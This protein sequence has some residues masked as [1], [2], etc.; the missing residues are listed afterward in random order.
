MAWLLLIVLSL[1]WGSS[2]IL[3]K[4]ALDV[5][6]PGEVGAIR[7][8]SAAIFI[9][10]VALRGLKTVQRKHWK[11]LLS[12]GFVGSL[13]PAFLFASAQTQL[14]SSV[15]GILNAL[16]PLFTMVI[17]ALFFSQQFTRKIVIGLIIGFAGTVIL[18]LAGRGNTTGLFNYHTL[19]VVLA[20]I[21]YGINLNITKY[22]LGDLNARVISGL[23]LILVGPVAL[24]Y[25][26]VG[27]NF[28]EKLMYQ[29]GALVSFG[30][31][32]LLGILGTA[33]ALI[34]F[35]QLVRITTPVFTSSVTYL[36]P[37]VAVIWGI[38]DGEH[39]YGGHYLGMAA[40]TLGVYLTNRGKK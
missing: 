3:I 20:T 31:V 5:F 7:I 27:T 11:Y 18:I 26:L 9:L 17:G 35:N 39:L 38:W 14:A 30:A 21:F 34:L 29:E 25:L 16:T 28:T 32:I 15:A 40:I 8:A 13:F 6:D 12:I 23:S 33:V 36:I 37:L 1:V 19:Y 10:P 22:K 2:F 24:A 4:Y